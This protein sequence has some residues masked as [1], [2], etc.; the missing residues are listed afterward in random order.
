MTVAP[1][2]LPPRDIHPGV[3]PWRA[4]GPRFAFPIVVAIALVLALNHRSSGIIGAV[5]ALAMFALIIP[6]EVPLLLRNQRRRQA[7]RM[8]NLPDGAFYA[9]RGSTVLRGHRTLTTGNMIFDEEGITF[10]PP[11]DK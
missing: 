7:E 5:G 4:L 10:I 2:P 1:P 9:C 11:R 3:S 6:I 8:Q